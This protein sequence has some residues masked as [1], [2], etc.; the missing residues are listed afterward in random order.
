MKIRIL[1]W[2]VRGENDS[3]KRKIIK[4]FLKTQKVDLV[5]LQETKLKGPSKELVSSLG[6][7]RF[8]DWAV[9]NA[10]G[11][12]CGILNLWDSRVLQLVGK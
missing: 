7:G 6:V 10:T 9:A 5:C 11:A 2:N 1:S 3:K 4:A 12:S 8:D